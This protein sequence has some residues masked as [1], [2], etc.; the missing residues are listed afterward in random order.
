MKRDDELQRLLGALEP[1]RPPESLR[2]R[3]LAAAEGAVFWFV[4]F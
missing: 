4:L 1:P 2:G 3:A